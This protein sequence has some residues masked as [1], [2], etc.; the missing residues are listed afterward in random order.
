MAVNGEELRAL[1][2]GALSNVSI[3]ESESNNR[4]DAVEAVAQLLEKLE[5]ERKIVF[6]F[7]TAE[8]ALPD[9]SDSGVSFT[10]IVD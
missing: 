7:K 1:L 8:E 2:L 5:R 4:F 3:S 10:R 6:L 9:L